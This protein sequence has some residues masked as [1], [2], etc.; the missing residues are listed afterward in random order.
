MICFFNLDLWHWNYKYLFIPL[1]GINLQELWC[2][3]A[4]TEASDDTVGVSNCSHN[5]SQL[6]VIKTNARKHHT[7]RRWASQVQ[8]HI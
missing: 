8:E 4:K 3:C 6:R 1:V 5:T 2:L 7:A